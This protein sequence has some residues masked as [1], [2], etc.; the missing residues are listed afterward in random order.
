MP[1]SFLDHLPLTT[2]IQGMTRAK[3]YANHAGGKKYDA[4]HKEIAKSTAHK[5]HEEKLEASEIFKAVWR[6]CKEH[7]AYQ[8]MKEEFMKEQKAWEKTKKL[9]KPRRKTDDDDD[10]DDDI[11]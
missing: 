10:D 9:Q 1:I 8:R 3:R 7:E 11:E 2:L 5:D 6:R 4:K